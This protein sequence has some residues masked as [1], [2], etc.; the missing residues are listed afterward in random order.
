M[1]SYQDH[2]ISIPLFNG[3]PDQ[4]TLSLEEFLSK[5]DYSVSA[6]SFT[7]E[8]A[9]ITFA[10]SLRG[11]AASWFSYFTNV[12]RS[13]PL[14]WN[15]IRPHFFCAFAA[16][17]KVFRTTTT[18][19]SF[20]NTNPAASTAPLAPNAILNGDITHTETAN[21]I[22]FTRAQT[23]HI[24]GMISA[25]LQN[26]RTELLDIVKFDD[27]TTSTTHIQKGGKTKQF[28]KLFCIYCRKHNHVAEKCRFRIRDQAPWNQT[29]T[30][31][32]FH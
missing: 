29:D 25:E 21:G 13:I 23:L 22:V 20:Y 7:Q 1:D 18:R 16:I 2:S 5:I 3:Q 14:R 10:N 24:K 19:R 17:F 12:N 8:M 31:S 32:V 27:T 9:Y 26:L 11:P 6:Y 28:T 4:D 30:S 15:S